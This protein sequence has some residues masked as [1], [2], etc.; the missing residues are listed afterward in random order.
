M[1]FP[2]NVAIF[3]RTGLFKRRPAVDAFVSLIK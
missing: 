2:K 3:L 1:C